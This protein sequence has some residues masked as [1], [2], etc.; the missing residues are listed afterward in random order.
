M[1]FKHSVWESILLLHI[2]W[3]GGICGVLYEISA[4]K[5]VRLY[6]I[7]CTSISAVWK[8][9]LS[10]YRGPTGDRCRHPSCSLTWLPGRALP[11]TESPVQ[12]IAKVVRVHAPLCICF[13]WDTQPWLPPLSS[14]GQECLGMN[15]GVCLVRA[16]G[17][18]HKGKPPLLL[19]SH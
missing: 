4:P 10:K 2:W 7:F 12:L 1:R 13:F 11:S 16:F 15:Y 3:G 6:S 14:L 19:F 17:F 18:G 5:W 8:Q 9:W